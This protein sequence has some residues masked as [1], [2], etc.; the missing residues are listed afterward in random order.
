MADCK[1]NAGIAVM[2]ASTE[3]MSKRRKV[4]ELSTADIDDGDDELGFGSLG[5]NSPAKCWDD[6]GDT[7]SSFCLDRSPASCCSSNESSDVVKDGGLQLLDPEEK[8]FEFEIADSTSIINNI[9]NN[10]RE[11]TPLSE[12]SVDSEE[13]ER[14]RKSPAAAAPPPADEIEEFFAAA[15]KSEQK[16]FAEKYNYDIVNDLPLPGRYH[17][18]ALAILFLYA[19]L[20]FID[21]HITFTVMVGVTSHYYLQ[22]LLPIS[23]F[24][25]E[26]PLLSSGI[27]VASTR[28]D[29]LLLGVDRTITTIVWGP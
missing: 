12:L 8:C 3:G 18:F 6:A 29:S 13:T 23:F 1:R 16:R 4:H 5:V 28:N 9:K 24:V 14:T 11:T 20:D 27:C 15:E 26:I 2:V 17:W 10:F 25:L 7:C 19:A 22:L 21:I